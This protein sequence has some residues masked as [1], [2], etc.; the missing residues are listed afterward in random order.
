MAKFCGDIWEFPSSCSRAVA[1][2]FARDKQVRELAFCRLETQPTSFEK[3]NFP[4]F[5][6]QNDDQPERL[7][8]WIS[9]EIKCQSEG[10]HLAEVALDLSTGTVRSVSHVLLEH[11]MA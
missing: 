7:R 6:L 3:I 9:S 5:L 4:S 1:A 10:K 11:L 2:R 8:T